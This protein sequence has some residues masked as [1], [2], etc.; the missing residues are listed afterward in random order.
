M[1]SLKAIQ[2]RIPSVKSTQK[3]TRAMKMVAGAR[4]ARAQQRIT[5]LRP[6]AV[7]T[8][9]VLRHVSGS[10]TSAAEDEGALESAFTLCGSPQ[11]KVLF[12]ILSSDKGFCGSLQL[13]HHPCG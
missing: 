8:G 13:E 9:E 6:Y 10:M 2:S 7:K 4:L 3:M 11:K 12:L 5:A 1:P